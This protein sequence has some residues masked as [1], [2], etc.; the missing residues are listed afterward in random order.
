MLALPIR[1][2]KPGFG[3]NFLK[4]DMGCLTLTVDRIFYSITIGS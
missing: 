3:K 2:D 4:N 1:T